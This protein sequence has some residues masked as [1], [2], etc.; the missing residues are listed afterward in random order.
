[1]KHRQVPGTVIIPWNGREW[2]EPADP[3]LSYIQG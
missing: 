2:V 1:M 3:T